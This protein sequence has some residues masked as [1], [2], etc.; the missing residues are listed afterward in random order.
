MTLLK[1]CSYQ[2]CFNT[3]KMTGLMYSTNLSKS[4][5]PPHRTNTL[6]PTPFFKQKTLDSI[7][8]TNLLSKLPK[9]KIDGK[10]DQKRIYQSWCNQSPTNRAFLITTQSYIEEVPDFPQLV[11]AVARGD[12][13]SIDI[14]NDINAYL[15][16]KK[17]YK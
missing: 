1:D 11:Q 4:A 17:H 2:C 13:A 15:E 10:K 3:L 9:L 8:L 12:I 7:E 16:D 5:P 6:F 14:Q